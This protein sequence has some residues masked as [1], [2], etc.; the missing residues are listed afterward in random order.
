MTIATADELR[1]QAADQDRAAAE[2][3]ER[4]D[5]DGFLSQWASGL[6]AS[7]L[8]A[9][10]ELAEQDGLIDINALFT[11]DGQVASTHH[12]WG[13]YGE[14]WVLTDAAADQF[15][16]RFFSPSKAKDPARAAATN[17]SKGFTVGSIRVRGHARILSGGTGLGGAASAR[18][19]IV[20]DI[21]ALRAGDYTIV[22]KENN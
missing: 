4:C 21:D 16:K 1:T 3:F 12:G 8:R 15:G 7:L 9:K 13:R 10:A 20:A 5:T 22:A 14:Y 17:R 19:T 6:S 2:S 18:A 11:L